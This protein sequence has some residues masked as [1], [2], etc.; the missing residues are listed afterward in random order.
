MIYQVFQNHQIFQNGTS[1]STSPPPPVPA[2]V[3][4]PTEN[5]NDHGSQSVGSKV[6]PPLMMGR[7]LLAQQLLQKKEKTKPVSLSPP[8]DEKPPSIEPSRTKSGTLFFNCSA[9]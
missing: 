6:A 4:K 2:G 7:G 5:T 8:L 1:S 9:Y 3:N